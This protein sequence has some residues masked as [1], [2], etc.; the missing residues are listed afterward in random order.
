[1]LTA[2]CFL[3][4]AVFTEDGAFFAVGD[5]GGRFV[6]DANDAAVFTADGAFFAV[7][8]LGGGFGPDANDVAVFTAD[9]VFFAVG[10]FGGGFVGDAND[11]WVVQTLPTAA[12]CNNSSL[13]LDDKPPMEG[14][15]SL[16]SATN[17]AT[18]NFDDTRV[19]D[20]TS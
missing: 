13:F 17:C 20:E 8:A 15:R 10:A 9:G 5:F 16:S 18:V 11:P 2:D 1:M 14:I 4:V 19:A 7:G 12:I 6:D 3:D